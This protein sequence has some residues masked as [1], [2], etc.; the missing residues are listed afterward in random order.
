MCLR[1][2]DS[3]AGSPD[4][5][6][7]V[8]VVAVLL[9]SFGVNAAAQESTSPGLRA[10]VDLVVNGVA[11]GDHLVVLRDGDVQVALSDLEAAG[12]GPLPG[13][14]EAIDG[15][16][17]LSLR[18]A[19]GAVQ[20]AFEEATLTLRVVADLSLFRAQH[21]RLR[22]GEPAGIRH[23][24]AAGAFFNYAAAMSRG[25]GHTLAGELGANLGP[26]LFTTTASWRAGA[27]PAQGLT[28]LT[29]DSRRRTQRLVVGESSVPG[30]G[31]AVPLLLAGLSVSR[32]FSLDPYFSRYPTPALSASV[33]TPSEAEVYVDGRLVQRLPLLP[34]SFDLT[35]IPSVAGPG[36]TSVVVRDAFGRTQEFGTTYYSTPSLL[37]PG[38][39]DYHYALGFRRADTAGGRVSYREPVAVARHRIG[40]VPGLTVGLS[41]EA[42]RGQVIATPALSVAAPRIGQVDISASASSNVGRTGAA[43]MLGWSYS[44]RA[45]SAG[46]SARVANAAYASGGDQAGIA[47]AEGSAF[48]GFNLASRISSTITEQESRQTP[49]SLAGQRT[50]RTSVLTTIRVTDHAHLM[51]TLAHQHGA[52]RSTVE[53]FAGVSLQVGPRSAALIGVDHR[54]GTSTPSVDIQKSRPVGEGFGYRVHGT[55]ISHPSQASAEYGGRWGVVAVDTVLAGRDAQSTLRAAGGIVV[56]SRG[57]A[58]TRSVEQGYAVVTV[59]GVAGVRVRLNNLEVGRTDSRG[60]LLVPSLL[61]NYGNRLTIEDSDVPDGFTV[62][63]A[64]LLIAPPARGAAHAV[65]GVVRMHAASGRLVVAASG[66]SARIV[67]AGGVLVLDNQRLQSP[68]GMNGE[69]FFDQLTPGR[70]AGFVEYHGTAYP[71][72]VVMPASGT[73]WADLGDVVAAEP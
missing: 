41:V 18:S 10:I 42:T 64:E 67:P 35:G 45:L 29:I 7:C 53:A 23:A 70:H 44:G 11:S 15:I 5:R 22:T 46:V 51:F 73:A 39:S 33:A 37:A 66:G 30:N 69:F 20:Y 47:R 63:E 13:R 32:E 8:A 25:G 55:D 31:L 48:I 72:E 4:V 54:S 58:L 57:L 26:T 52:E 65:F 24:R 17:Y 19:G 50:S 3:A 2:D 1:P 56:T 6:C 16:S 49:A 27:R 40:I 36:R 14:L 9:A 68:I 12:L 61:S 71:V 21:V 62:P 60:N 34:G 43:A 28:S 59:P 38:L